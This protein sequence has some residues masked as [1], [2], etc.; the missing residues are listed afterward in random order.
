MFKQI[1]GGGKE[2]L[3]LAIPLGVAVDSHDEPTIAQFGGESNPLPLVKKSA[4]NNMRKEVITVL[5]IGC[6][7]AGVAERLRMGYEFRQESKHSR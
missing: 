5:A 6:T 3:L 7:A 2:N 4:A 1:I